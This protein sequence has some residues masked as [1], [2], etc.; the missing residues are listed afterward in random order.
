LNSLAEA[1]A[2]VSSL[3]RA[4]LLDV[5]PGSEEPFLSPW[6]VRKLPG[7]EKVSEP[8]LFEDLNIQRI[9]QLA[10][11]PVCHLATAFGYLGPV[12]HQRAHGIDPRPVTP[13]R[14]KPVV[15]EEEILAE[16]TNEREKL[17]AS[18]RI[19]TERCGYRLRHK[20]A[21]AATVILQVGYTDNFVLDGSAHVGSASNTD[22]VLYGAIRQ[23]YY[24][25]GYR[26]VRVRYLSLTFTD[27]RPVVT[28]LE[29]FPLPDRSERENPLTL[30]LDDIR[31]RYGKDAIQR[32]AA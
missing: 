25:V 5:L 6:Q 10:A 29:L 27:L 9:G 26:R 18:L 24:R 4:D 30:A 31:K 1:F 28:Q 7:T 14:S 16:E 32:G 20:G 11:C 8:R 17:Q 13:P 22:E 21:A 15:H 3:V 2:V 19:L 23:L 12:L